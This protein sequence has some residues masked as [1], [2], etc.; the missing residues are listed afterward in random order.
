MFLK[1][2]STRFR[3]PRT[4]I[5][6]NVWGSIVEM[7]VGWV[8]GRGT[9]CPRWVRAPKLNFVRVRFEPKR[10]EI[11]RPIAKKTKKK[12]SSREIKSLHLH[13]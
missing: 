9:S 12:F 6:Q 3:D 11:T 2:F 7:G 10:L 5:Q 1:W 4:R 8:F 13:P